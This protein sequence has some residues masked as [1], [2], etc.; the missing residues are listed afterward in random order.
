VEGLSGKELAE[1]LSKI[2]QKFIGAGAN[3]VIPGIWDLFQV[4][5]SVN[6]RLTQGLVPSDSLT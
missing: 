2:E 1:K 6:E 5:E 3:F 4:I